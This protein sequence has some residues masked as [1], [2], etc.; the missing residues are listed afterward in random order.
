MR[1]LDGFLALL[2]RRQF[3]HP[4]IHNLSRLLMFLINGPRGCPSV[5]SH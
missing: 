3:M 2:I 5:T 4:D 1:A